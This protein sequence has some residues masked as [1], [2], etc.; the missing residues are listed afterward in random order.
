MDSVSALKAT[1]FVLAVGKNK[2][3][4]PVKKTLEWGHT[5]KIVTDN[6]LKG[7]NTRAFYGTYHRDPNYGP[8]YD[9]INKILVVRSPLDGSVLAFGLDDNTDP[10]FSS[11]G[12][13]GIV[14]FHMYSDWQFERLIG[15]IDSRLLIRPD[16]KVSI[17]LRG[18]SDG[19]RIIP[20]N[21]KNKIIHISSGNASDV[22]IDSLDDDKGSYCDNSHDNSTW[23]TDPGF[24]KGVVIDGVKVIDGA[25]I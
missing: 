8:V 22:E 14:D 9:W 25:K 1:K 3:S 18:A 24:F 10:G 5:Y 6:R 2:I 16:H 17:C 20:V 4:N 15:S 11:Y 19:R 13:T 23:K 7:D 12:T 21:D